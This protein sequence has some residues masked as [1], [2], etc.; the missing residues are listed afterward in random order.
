MTH[1]IN[2]NKKVN[3][4]DLMTSHSFIS[5]Y[6]DGRYQ[7]IF[8]LDGHPEV[9]AKTLRNHYGTKESTFSLIQHGDLIKLGKSI[10][11]SKFYDN[12]YGFNRTFDNLDEMIQC[13][14]ECYCQYG[15]IFIGDEWVSYNIHENGFSP[16]NLELLTNA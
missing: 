2:Y 5:I 10:K 6:L 7:S 4:K 13:Y 8:C 11:N 3:S 14:R 1:F 16:A 15:Y 12:D 9:L